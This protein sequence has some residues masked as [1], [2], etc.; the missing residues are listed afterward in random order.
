MLVYIIVLL[1]L[2]FF[3]FRYLKALR[4][5]DINPWFT[6]LGY[7]IKVIIGYYFIFVYSNVYGSGTLSADAGAFMSESEILNNVFYQSPKDYFQLLFGIGDQSNLTAQYLT[8]THHWDAGEQAILNDN[9][10]I[11]RIQ[12]V[13]QFISFGNA[14]IHMLV[15]CLVSMIGVK[16]LYIGIKTRTKVSANKTFW[17]LF[18]IP[19]VLFW[20]SGILKEPFMFL[21]LGLFIR[22]LLGNDKKSKKWMLCIGGILL[23]IAFKPYIFLCIIPATIF[24][25]LYNKLPKFKLLGSLIILTFLLSLPII[26]FKSTSQKA[27]TLLSRK[28]FDFINVARGGLHIQ[29]DTNFIFFNAMQM[30]KLTYKGDSIK[31]NQPMDVLILQHGSMDEPIPL[32]IQPSKKYY[33]IYFRNP[34]SDGYIPITL[35]NNSFAQ[36]IYNIPEALVNVLLRPYFTDPGS[37]LKY[38]A[39]IELIFIYALLIYAYINRRN[40]QQE[41]KALI[42]AALIFIFLLALTI[43]WVTPVLGAIVR[44]RLPIL[45]GLVLI[46]LIIL[47]PNKEQKV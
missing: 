6:S 1:L 8:E 25:Y 23:L 39:A 22:A 11:L 16:H 27:L 7:L 12:S 31:V 38:L 24:Y 20:T 43:G 2:F 41:D 5:P 17:I 36:L 26:I 14:T 10:N 21:G 30:D 40:L 44:Y 28:Q 33:Y 42:F 45:I 35:I 32:K 34:Q 13:I 4:I 29:N 19:S 3:G 18:L 15:M 47:N 37:W 9:R 46:S